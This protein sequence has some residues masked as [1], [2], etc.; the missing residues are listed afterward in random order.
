[1]RLHPRHNR[2][3]PAVVRYR[4]ARRALQTPASAQSRRGLDWM[5]FFIADVQTGFGTFV[6]F[7][8][9]QQGWSHDRIGVALSVGGIAGVLSQIPGGALTD[10][11]RWKR[12]LIAIGIVAIG[13][14]AL[15]L[16]L[17]PS[18]VSVLAAELLHGVTA[19][20]ITPAIGAISLGLVGR[21]AMSLRTGRNYRYAAAGHVVTA[22]LMGAAGAYLFSGGMF[23]AAAA[24]CIPALVA[25]AF[26]RGDEI[27]YARARNAATGKQGAKVARVLD[28]ARNHKLLLFTL[29]IVLFQLAD[30]SLLPL[31]GEN[32]A[33]TM[34][35]H[36]SLW[37][38]VLVMIPQVVV[39]LFAPWVGY[40]SERKGRRPLLLIAFAIEPVRAILLAFTSD[41]A[42]LIFG[43]LLNGVSG[44][45]IGVL[46][47]IVVTDLTAGT[48]RFNLAQG[49][50]GALSGLAASVSTLAT[51]YIVA[52]LGAVAGYL[53]IAAV[54]IAATALLWVFLSETKPEK[55]AD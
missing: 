5:N 40:H 23:I 39:A 12:G 31:I 37:M 46:T 33:A 22:G 1:M 41:Y 47:V 18:F 55:Y 17:E 54:A 50:V 51:G 29:A 42:L 15:L 25:L 13:I 34:P 38:S 49:T 9:A 44:A 20:I 4:A 11:L 27:D 36:A 2:L 30:A 10:A 21:R 28:L 24:L 6:A 48:G 16:A 26:I 32:V 53:A 43:Q 14:A 52:G 3:R 45:V 19:G 7:Y 35:E 8:L